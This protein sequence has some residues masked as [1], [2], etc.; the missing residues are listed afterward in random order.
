[1]ARNGPN[2]FL[3]LLSM[4]LEILKIPAAVRDKRGY[5]DRFFVVELLVYASRRVGGV[6]F[7]TEASDA[8]WH[9]KAEIMESGGCG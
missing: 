6:G 7:V 4:M 9:D 3:S 1:M 5:I 8:R 2:I